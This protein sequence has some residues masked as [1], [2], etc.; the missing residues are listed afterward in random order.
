[1]KKTLKIDQRAQKEIGRLPKTAILRLY[2]LFEILEKE[3]KLEPPYAKK[4]VG[5]SDLF[6]LRII[7]S[8]QYRS[9]Y[10]YLDN[11]NI[12][13]LTAFEKK[14]NKT[15]LKHLQTAKKRKKQYENI[16]K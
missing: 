15:P 10:A 12:I 11:D 8:G 5:T 9:I 2:A 4:L 1:M 16:N 6:E 13:I 14:T 3:G 7:T